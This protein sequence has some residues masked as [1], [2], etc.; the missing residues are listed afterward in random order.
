[1]KEPLPEAYELVVIAEP[2]DEPNGLILGQRISRNRFLTLINFRVGG[3]RIVSALENID[4][5][6]F[7]G[8]PTTV[9]G[10]QLKM[11]QLSQIVV[12]V[13]K[14]LVTVDCDG[15]PLIRWTGDAKR[16]TLSDYWATKHADNLFLGAYDCRYRFHRVTLTPLKN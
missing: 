6:N 5:Q 14:S 10:A 1:M 4:G 9:E 16:L 12:R 13:Q 11:N 3:E 2:L 8:G 15:R 7:D